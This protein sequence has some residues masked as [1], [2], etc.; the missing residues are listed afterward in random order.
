MPAVTTVCLA[1]LTANENG[2]LSDRVRGGA[3]TSILL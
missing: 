3:D 1:A 2:H